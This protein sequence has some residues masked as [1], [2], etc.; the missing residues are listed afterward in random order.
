M[1]EQLDH[2]TLI[3][4]LKAEGPFVITIDGKLHRVIAA[5]RYRYPSNFFDPG[6]GHP[7]KV[8]DSIVTIEVDAAGNPADF[9]VTHHQ[10]RLSMAAGPYTF[11]V[12]HPLT[13]DELTAMLVLAGDRQTMI[14]WALDSVWSHDVAPPAQVVDSLLSEWYHDTSLSLRLGT[15]PSLDF[16]SWYACSQSPAQRNKHLAAVLLARG[17]MLA[18]R[19]P[20][21]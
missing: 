12:R 15:L 20:T 4:R 17:R 16:M 2:A 1:A 3:A 6:F 11:L 19:T 7:Q 13:I 21:T 10:E 8:D 18:A 14:D 9:R 5:E